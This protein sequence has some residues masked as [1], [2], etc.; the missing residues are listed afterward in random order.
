MFRKGKEAM[1]SRHARYVGI[2]QGSIVKGQDLQIGHLMLSD[3]G[4]TVDS[5]LGRKPLP[6][7]PNSCWVTLPQDDPLPCLLVENY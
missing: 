5:G 7:M 1:S 3:M 4:L 6:S 2:P